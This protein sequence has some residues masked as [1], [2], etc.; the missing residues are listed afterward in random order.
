[1][2]KSTITPVQLKP[3]SRTTMNFAE[4]LN[5]IAKRYQA[6]K[7]EALK[8]KLKSEAESG[9]TDTILSHTF[10]D[11]WCIDWLRDQGFEVEET[12]DQ[13]DGSFIKVSW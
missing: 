11:S 3:K 1:M 9:K 12:V 4:E 10:Y 5:N 6:P 13:R 2:L 8:A 7:L